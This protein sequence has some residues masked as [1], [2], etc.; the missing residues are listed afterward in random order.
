MTVPG[1]GHDA[2]VGLEGGLQ[3]PG[4]EVAASVVEEHPDAGVLCREVGLGHAHRRRVREAQRRRRHGL[5]TTGGLGVDL[6]CEQRQERIG[7]R[8]PAGHVDVEELE[9]ARQGVGPE[10]VDVRAVQHGGVDVLVVPQGGD[11]RR[12]LG[13]GLLVLE[14]AHQE[15]RDLDVG[16]PH[17]RRALVE[18]RRDAGEARAHQRLELLGLGVQALV[19]EARGVAGRDLGGRPG[20]AAFGR[21]LGVG[22]ALGHP[23]LGEPAVVDPAGVAGREEVVGGAERRDGGQVRRVGARHLELG[24]ARVG[25]AR[26]CPP[27]GAAPRIGPRPSGSRRS[28]RS[29]RAARRGRRP[30]PS[31]PCRASGR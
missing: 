25:D 10:R 13:T 28:R 26:P 2:V 15:H 9:P 11:Q 29:P 21:G 6:R 1:G 5:R 22:D 24:D 7:G 8:H 4:A 17:R 3:G 27:C 20:L 19:G 12:P 18:Q 30:H 31:T 14:R 16:G 23:A